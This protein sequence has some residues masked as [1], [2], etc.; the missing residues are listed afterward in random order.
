MQRPCGP[1]F[2][3]IP[4]DDWEAQT[5]PVAPRDVSR[6]AAPDPRMLDALVRALATA[7]RPAFVSGP[8]VDMERAG[9]AAVALA[10]RSR[11]AVWAAPFSSNVSFP[12]EHPRF[13]GFLPAAPEPVSDALSAYD[14]IVVLGAPVFTFHVAGDCA[15]FRSGIPLFQITAN[16][17]AAASS[18]LGSAI[19]ASLRLALSRLNELLP[20][21]QRTALAPRRPKKPPPAADPIPAEFLM[22]MIDVTRP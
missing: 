2:V 14:L 12:E 5:R 8:E 1:A 22:H 11:A 10:E 16:G 13:A 19:I 7:E 18:P 6:D 9:D 20:A 17:D 15:L 21:T 4:I 3:S